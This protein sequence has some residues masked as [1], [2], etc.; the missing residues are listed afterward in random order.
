MGAGATGTSWQAGTVRSGGS[1]QR[2]GRGGE[3]RVGRQVER[4]GVAE[5]GVGVGWSWVAGRGAVELE[6][7]RQVEVAVGR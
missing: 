5:A 2:A 6:S 4:G 7:E 3:A 1:E